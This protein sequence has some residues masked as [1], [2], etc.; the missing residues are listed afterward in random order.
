MALTSSSAIA[1]DE[2][3]KGVFTHKEHSVDLDQPITIEAQHKKY[4][5]IEGEKAQ[6]R[7]KA[8]RTYIAN[9]KLVR[10]NAIS[11]EKI[12]KGDFCNLHT[13]VPHLSGYNVSDVMYVVPCEKPHL[14]RYKLREPPPLPR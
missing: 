11:G 12:A 2:W 8:G 6:E 7:K 1:N 14:P 5:L 10:E 3:V 13:E 9:K 4:Q